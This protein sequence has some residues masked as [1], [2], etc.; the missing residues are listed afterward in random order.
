M[1]LRGELGVDEM[2][3]C[4]GWI[5]G[6]IFIIK[7]QIAQSYTTASYQNKLDNYK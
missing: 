1:L 2:W 6:R 7:L 3:L 5:V 4:V